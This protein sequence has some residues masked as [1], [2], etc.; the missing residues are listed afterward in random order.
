MEWESLVGDTFGIL[1][2]IKEKGRRSD[3]DLGE[4]V[5]VVE[6]L[7]GKVKNGY[8][9]IRE[10]KKQI[11]D[12]QRLIERYEGRSNIRYELDG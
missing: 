4:L 8:E 1:E 6:E 5:K 7:I 10:L 3:E 9:A 11:G 12:N 2:E